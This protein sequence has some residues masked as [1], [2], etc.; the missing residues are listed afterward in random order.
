MLVFTHKPTHWTP[1]VLGLNKFGSNPNPPNPKSGLAVP[2]PVGREYVF[3][4]EGSSFVPDG[5]RFVL[6]RSPSDESLGYSRASLR[7]LDSLC[8][9]IRSLGILPRRSGVN[10]ALHRSRGDHA[11]HIPVGRERGW[12]RVVVFELRLPSGRHRHSRF[13]SRFKSCAR[14]RRLATTSS[15]KSIPSASALSRRSHSI[16]PGR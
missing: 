4:E 16:S 15:G 13:K 11:K 3:S 9:L 5:T 10:A 2:S 14:P 1:R 12:V 7:D 8:V 6:A